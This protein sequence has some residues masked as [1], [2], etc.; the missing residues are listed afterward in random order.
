MRR[1]FGLLT[2]FAT[3]A[4]CDTGTPPA[5]SFCVTPFM[6]IPLVFFAYPGGGATGVSTSIGELVFAGA[7]SGYRVTLTGPGKGVV[8]TGPLGPAPSPLPS[9]IVPPPP[10]FTTFSSVTVPKLR[11]ASTYAVAYSYTGATGVPPNCVGTVT[12]QLGAFSTR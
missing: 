1:L 12:R 10:G 8:P 6:P 2:I 4:A 9:P 11:P 7:T 5:Q 3:L